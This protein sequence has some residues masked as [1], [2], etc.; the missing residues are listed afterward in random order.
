MQV[1]DTT[2]SVYIAKWQFFKTDRV[3]EVALGNGMICT[4]MNNSRTHSAVQSAVA[5]PA[6]GTPSSDKLGYDGSGRPITKRYLVSTVNSYG[7]YNN[8][9][10]A[11][12]FTTKY[13][14]AGSKLFERA[15]HAENRSHL[16]EPYINGVPQGGYDSLN[17]L[18]QY[19]RGNLSSTGGPSNLGGGSITTTLNLANACSNYTY[20]LD[21]LGNWRRATYTLG[22][23]TTQQVR[24][25]NGLNEITRVTNLGGSTYNFSYDG[26]PGASNGNL[27]ND[28]TLSYTWDA[29]NRLVQ[30]QNTAGSTIY[31]NYYYDALGRRIRK[32]ISS[33]GGLPGGIP[34][35]TIDCLYLGWRCVEDRNPLGGGGGTTDTPLKQ[36]TRGIYLDEL[37]QQFNV[38]SINGFAINTPLYPL[39]DLL[40]RTTGLADS[41][42]IIREAYDTDAYGNTLIF[43]NTSNS[44]ITW[45]VSYPD[46]QVTN[47]TCEF[48][49]TGQRFDAETTNYYYKARYYLPKWGR[50]GSR[51]FLGFLIDEFNLFVYSLGTPVNALDGD[52]LFGRPLLPNRP[53]QRC[54][55]KRYCPPPAPPIKSL[56]EY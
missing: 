56:S 25:H 39:Q 13:D 16:Y 54:C 21:G 10:P 48:I 30:V 6:W 38:A 28:G 50:F 19:Q 37:L 41:S 43:R 44:V 52:G 26:V 34:A 42:G 23:A 36:Y 55:R 17:R 4:Y 29:L 9:T 8:S 47:P 5:N 31:A 35:G 49:F 12:G 20:T 24:Q 7:A 3:A 27:A 33:A 18:L 22:G 11:V 14:P 40:Y 1:Q 45:S 2:N 53:F 15:L 32:L 46:T 51:D